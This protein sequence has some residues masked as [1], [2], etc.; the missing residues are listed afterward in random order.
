MEDTMDTIFSPSKAGTS[1]SGYVALAQLMENHIAKIPAY[2]R[3]KKST[4]QYKCRQGFTFDFYSD[5]DECSVEISLAHLT[6]SEIIGLLS[7]G[8]LID[9]LLV[10]YELAH[11]P[12]AEYSLMRID[13]LECEI[14]DYVKIRLDSA[15]SPLDQSQYLKNWRPMFLKSQSWE[16]ISLSTEEYAAMLQSFAN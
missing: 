2:W 13:G 1:N 6:K 15:F 8:K 9:E 3:H 16:D 7:K 14:V 12:F 5:T 11:L 10:L 4:G